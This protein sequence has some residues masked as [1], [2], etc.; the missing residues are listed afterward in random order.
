MVYT[1]LNARKTDILLDLGGF[2]GG[3]YIINEKWRVRGQ[4]GVARGTGVAT[5]TLEI[6]AFFGLSYY[7]ND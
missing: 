7:V 5:T 2:G 1:T 6:K 4:L 3:T